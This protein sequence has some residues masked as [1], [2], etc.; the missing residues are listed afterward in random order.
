MVAA[1]KPA[2]DILTA[3]SIRLRPKNYRFAMTTAAIEFAE[4]LLPVPTAPFHEH[5]VLA[6]AEAICRE[7]LLPFHRDRHGNLIVDLPGDPR[8]GDPLLLVAHADHPGFWATR[9]LGQNVLQARWCG[10]LP[11][12]VFVGQRLRFETSAGGQPE[13]VGSGVIETISGYRDGGDH[14]LVAVRLDEPGDVP[15]HCVGTW[16]LPPLEID[17]PQRD[18]ESLRTSA[19]MI[20]GTSTDDV[21]AVA[22]LL[23]AATE[24]NQRAIHR[25]LRLLITRAEEAGFVGCYGYC[26]DVLSGRDDRHRPSNDPRPAWQIIGVEMSSALSGDWIGQGPIVRVGDK[27]RLFNPEVTDHCLTAAKTLADRNASF[28]FARRL[29][30]GGTCESSVMDHYLGRCGAL[31]LALGNYHNLNRQ[32]DKI[33]REYISTADYL[34]LVD[35]LV[36]IAR[37]GPPSETSMATEFAGE[38]EFLF[39]SQEHLLHEQSIDADS[40]SRY[41]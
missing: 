1:G 38:C 2:V 19:A 4:R 30:P 17:L 33:D 32:S 5:G 6:V 7:S 35:L 13:V 14:A 20:R 21:A 41:E 10:Q 11:Q 34:D 39:S 24:L 28:R 29:M 36:A 8:H 15:A 40:S 16:D 22:A 18:R 37:G 3:F 26:H 9:R 25:P 12:H 31:C 27:R 23:A